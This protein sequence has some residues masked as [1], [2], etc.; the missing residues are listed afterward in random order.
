MLV[1]LQWISPHFSHGIIMKGRSVHFLL[2]IFI[3]LLLSSCSSPVKQRASS[4]QHQSVVQKEHKTIDILYRYYHDWRG[5]PYR[6]GGLSKNGVDCSGFVYLAYR[7]IAGIKL[8]RTTRQQM[9]LGSDVSPYDLEPGDLVFFKTGWNKRHV[10]IY[11][12]N[13]QFMHASTSHGV[14]LSGLSEKYW[15]DTFYLAKRLNF[16]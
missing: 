4:I 15:Q 5:T 12:Q 7:S 11:M 16:R 8:P 14:M 1:N 2:F 10:G 9:R 6:L 13:G 3:L